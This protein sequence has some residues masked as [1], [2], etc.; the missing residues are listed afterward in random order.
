M[1]LFARLAA[2]LSL[3]LAT[4]AHAGSVTPYTADAYSQALTAG[5]PVLVQVHADWCPTCRAQAPVV[6]KLAADPKY[7]AFTVLVVDYDAQKDVRKQL[8]VP[9]QS[10]LLV[11]KG[12]AEVAR[13]T[14]ITSADSISALL[15]KAL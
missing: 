10:T 12:G 9:R 13:A 1:S 14:G 11:F 8:N 7:A 15:D 4:V 5:T 6:A 3:F 2:V